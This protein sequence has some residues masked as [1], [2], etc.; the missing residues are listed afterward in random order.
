MGLG[1][2]TTGIISAFA[3]GDSGIKSALVAMFCHRASPAHLMA[4]EKRTLKI[5]D[6][7]VSADTQHSA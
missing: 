6:G 5:S 4:Q 2:N 7:A 1:S 3:L